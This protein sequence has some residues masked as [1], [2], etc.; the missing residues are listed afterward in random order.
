MSVDSKSTATSAKSGGGK[1]KKEAPFLER[2]VKLVDNS[3]LDHKLLLK[4]MHTKFVAGFKRWK[5]R[6]SRFKIANLIVVLIVIGVQVGQVVIFQLNSSLVSAA[7]KKS[8]ATI[9]PTVTGAIL[10]LQMKLAW[11]DKAAKCKKSTA[12]YNKLCK[13]TEYRM[14]MLDAGGSFEDTTTIWN[15]ALVTESKD[16]P[17][18]LMAY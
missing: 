6:S 10:A 17:A 5:S 15:T 13:H 3:A 7:T 9:L 4:T 11:A 18:Y 2:E 16:V 8:I 1:K 12:I 14:D